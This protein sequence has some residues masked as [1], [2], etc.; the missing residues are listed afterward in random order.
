MRG[1]GWRRIVVEKPFGRDLES[2]RSPQPRGQQGLPRVAGLPHRPLPGQGDGPQP[3]GLPL[4]QRHLRAGL[5]PQLR[6]PRADHRG[7]VDR[8]GE[9][10]RLL[11]G[12]RREPRHPPEPP[13]PAHDAS[14]RWS[15]RPRSRPTR[16]ATRSSRSCGRSPPPDAGERPPRRRPRPVRAG[17][18]RRRGRRR[19]TARSRRSIP[20]SE[21]ETYV[22]G[23]FTIDD[24]R[25]S[26]VPFYLRAGKRLPKRATEIAIQFKEVPLRLF[27]ESAGDPAP[28]VLAMRIQP[29]EG[30]MLRF[31]AKVPGLGLDVRTVNMDFAYD[32]SFVVDSPGRVR[33]ADPGRAPGRRL[34]LHP[35]RRGGGGLVRR[36]ADHQRLGGDA[37]AALPRLRRGNVGPGGGRRADGTGRPTV[38]QD[39]KP[40]A[41][42][43]SKGGRGGLP[44]RPR[45]RSPIPCRRSRVSSRP[46]GRAPRLPAPRRRAPRWPL[47]EAQAQA[48][49]QAAAALAAREPTGA[50]ER[51]VAARS[52]VLNLIVVAGRSET[53]ERCAATIAGTA[54]RHPSRSLIL[55]AVDPD[56]PPGLDAR[57]EALA[58]A[59][60]AGRAETGAETIHVTARG[61]TG[62]HLASIIVPLLVH[63]L[64]VAL[65]WPDDPKFESHRADR[66]LPM[67]DRLIVDGSSWSGDGMDRLRSY[68]ARGAAA[69]ALVVAD[70]ALL[71]QARWREALASV[72][73]LPDLRPHLRAVRSITVEFAAADEDDPAGS[74]NVV[75]PRLPRG[76]AGVPSRDERG[77]ASSARRRRPARGHPP[78]AR[79]QGR[80]RAAPGPVGPGTGIDRPGGDR[81]AAARRRADRPCRRPAIGP[82]R[83]AST[84]R[85]A[86]ESGAPTWRPGS[87]T[88]TCWSERWRKA[89]PIRSPP[90]SWP[91]PGRLIGVGADGTRR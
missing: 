53:A 81:L 87:T 31:A 48:A 46:C 6:G 77:V 80:G 33:D 9:P 58:L 84:T 47:A 51:H 42:G 60:A 22:A 18:G 70:F 91:R 40:R 67:A 69:S 16:C 12:D 68:G 66:L 23:R 44:R 14:W 57:I 59:T 74:T 11:R 20:E 35:R 37:G 28:N 79:T 4:R 39:L 54:G 43:T 5:E 61:E 32:T 73:D 85:A 56:G 2:A 34:A 26:G 75:R 71:R 17:L 83:W 76:L 21:T 29:D 7:R 30:I 78:P 10:R 63:D 72:Y 25:W 3:A 89:P 19:A 90:K 41:G 15:R 36:D 52:S 24:W 27:R 1:A 8:R 86:S 62:Q 45:C 88:K 50:G 82:S 55:S 65:W 64:P 13:A 49:A 38:A